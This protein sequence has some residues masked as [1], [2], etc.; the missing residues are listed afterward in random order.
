MVAARGADESTAW[1][2]P[3]DLV[4][5]CDKATSE[6]PEL[7]TLGR[8]APCWSDQASLA[9]DLLG[10]D[11]VTII[12]ALKAAVR[13]GATPID[14]GQSLAY[15]AALRV[16]RFGNANEHS[17]WETA[18]HVFTYANAVHQMLRRIGTAHTDAQVATVRARRC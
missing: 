7:F 13:A 17:D 5:L 8:G 18:H 3:V 4:V 2:Q 15:A 14:L 10:D 12:V 6:L 11:P 16:A 1:R 9:R